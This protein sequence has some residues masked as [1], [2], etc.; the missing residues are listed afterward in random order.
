MRRFASKISSW[1]NSNSLKTIQRS[2]RPLS[3]RLDLEILEGRSVPSAAAPGVISGLAFVDS[4]ATGI[5]NS[6]EITLP[7][8]NVTLTG[9]TGIG[10]SVSTTTTTDAGGAFS[11][12]N[13]PPGTYQLSAPAGSGIL[14][15]GPSFGNTQ[16]PEGTDLISGIAVALGQTVHQN[17]GFSGLA[18]SLISMRLFLSSTT[19]ADIPLA[20]GGNGSGTANYHTPTVRTPI[21]DVSLGK[22]SPQTSMDLATHFTDPDAHTFVRFDTSDGP[23]NVQLFDGQAPQTVANFL[24][25]VHSGAYDNSI[26]HR[27]AS[28]FVLQGGGFT[29]D[30]ASTSFAS[31]PTNP[32]IQNEFG[33]SNTQGTLAMAQVGGDINSATDEFFFNLVDNSSTLDP[34]K[35]A[36]FGK[37]I[38]LDDQNVLNA[39]AA[40]PV[41]NESSTNSAFNTLPLAN[42]TGTNFPTDTTTSNYLIVKDVAI[43][44]RDLTY[45]VVSNSNPTLLAASIDP[46]DNAL[47]DM[48]P[49]TNQTGTATIVVEATDQYGASVTASF[50]VTVTE[51]KPTATVSLSPSSPLATDSLTATA[52]A[53]DPDGDPVTLT[54]NWQIN[55]QTVQTTASTS[56]LTDTLNLNGQQAKAGDTVTVTVTPNDGSTI[57][58]TAASSTVTVH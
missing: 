42:Y 15:G 16:G 3:R 13:V 26:F 17:L 31:I 34:Q 21:A 37:I 48:R 7:G 45:S 36:V 11:F 33:A 18:P 27:L 29:F 24:N 44:K 23:I 32:S 12:S 38:G 35:F 47:V 5:F 40:T 6:G 10:T 49:S 30:A 51:Q 50:N 1:F 20:A 55:G 57:D 41:K 14:A 22:N 53:S 43:V 4:A 9:T 52:T 8:M 28:G 54:Y 39:L 19:A 25:Y 2:R 56:N 46:N 58:G